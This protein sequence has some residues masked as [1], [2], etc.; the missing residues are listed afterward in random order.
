[1]RRT[2]VLCAILIVTA[3][4]SNARAWGCDGHRAIAILAER[5]LSASQLSAVRAILLASRPDPSLE[6]SCA[7]VPADL[8]A[9]SSTWADDQ[10]A[11]EPATGV[12]HFINFPRTFG[13]APSS[14][15]P[16]CLKGGCVI[17]A[18]PR[19]FRLARISTNPAVKAN[20]VRYLLHFVG[21]VHQPLHAITNGDRGAN[22]LPVSYYAQAPLEED[23][24]N[25]SPNLHGVWDTRTIRTLMNDMGLSGTQA[26]AGYL[27]QS[28]FPQSVAAVTPTIAV[29]KEWASDA[30]RLARTVAYAKLPA[31]VPIDAAAGAPLFSCDGNNHVSHRLAG[32]HERVD[33]TYEQ[34]SVPAIE[35]QLRL[36]G[37]RLA[38]V[39]KASLP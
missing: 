9:E 12:W 27:A 26:L 22:C 16:Y 10:R 2:L 3:A 37:Q 13:A 11:V 25:F 1:M 35:R 5:L 21:D 36:A 23:E 28:Q 15:L 30:N 34:A 31:S 19:Q 24:G 29:V 39:L 32:L 4:R 18:I 17:D 14:H 8:V 20:A 33:A 38:A 6:R 7:P